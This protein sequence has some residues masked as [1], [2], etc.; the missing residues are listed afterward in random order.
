MTGFLFSREAGNKTLLLP[1]G[2]D[3]LKNK[4]M[5]IQPGKLYDARKGKAVSFDGMI[6]KMKSGRFIYIGESHDSLPMHDI[7]KRII[8]GLCHK[9]G[10]VT[11]GLEMFTAEQ[12]EVLNRWSLGLME[13]EEFI[14]AA[15]WYV[16]W[17]FHFD[18][19]APIF[20]LVK[21]WKIPMYGLNAERKIIS[22][23]RMRGWDSLTPA[24][25]KIVPEPDISHEEHRRL[26]RTI[27][28]EADLPPQMKGRGL[29]MVF[30]GL[31]RA[32]SAWDEVMAANAVK[33]AEIE[34]SKVVVL[35]GSGHLM[36]NLGIN[37]RVWEKSGRP[38][39]TVICVNVP[40]DQEKTTV[41]RSLADFIWALP[42]EEK[43]AFPAPGL[44][45]KKSE[46]L[47]NLF[48]AEPSVTGA[49]KNAGFEKGDVILKVNGESFFDINELR[50][51][52][53]R[54][55]WGDTVLFRVLRNGEEREI[56]LEYRYAP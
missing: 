18:Y 32:Q 40:S 13:E 23:I 15:G 48:I 50:R 26:I 7:Q 9:Y 28:E 5:E 22:K 39:L 4:T 43:P 45:L 16:T 11:V 51:Y 10:E 20:R 44:R 53:A 31:Y 34:R 30:E 54:F 19:Y 27:F 38:F 3:S 37:R 6:E 35:A 33:A 1:I 46:G 14:R 36:Y 21:E 47:D 55:T 29:D 25:K 12:Q 17:N 2:N 24:E 56:E 42:E 52:L 49:A 41:V 8:E